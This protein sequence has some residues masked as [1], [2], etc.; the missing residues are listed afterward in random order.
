MEPGERIAAVLLVLLIGSILIHDVMIRSIWVLWI[1]PLALL[2]GSAALLA[3][4]NIGFSL[5]DGDG[6][7][8][9][10]RGAVAIPLALTCAIVLSLAGVGRV[11]AASAYLYA[12]RGEMDAAQ[13]EA[14][15]G[16]PVAMRYLEGVPNGGVAIIRSTV[17][18]RA[19]PMQ[20][21]LRLTGER[22]KFCRPILFAA[23]AC[24]YD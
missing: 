8:R 3:L 6:V 20:V 7:S 9:K 12:H 5:R 14:G 22:I 11:V 21:Q 2:W 13:A 23:Y 19:L 16:Q 18:P 15:P 1:I 4:F 10:V 24:T 17:P